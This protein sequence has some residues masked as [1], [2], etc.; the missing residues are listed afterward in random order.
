[1]NEGIDRTKSNRSKEYMTCHYWFLYH[2]SRLQDSVVFFVFFCL[3]FLSQP[4]TNHRTAG[5]V[6]G[7]SFNSSLPISPVSHTPTY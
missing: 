7:H 6:G 5:E 3:C 1:M 2:G 4:F